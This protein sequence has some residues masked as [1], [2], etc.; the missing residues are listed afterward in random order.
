MVGVS[1]NYQVTDGAGRLYAGVRFGAWMVPVGLAGLA[2]LV[3]AT[4]N[5]AGRLRP[6]M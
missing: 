6:S 2:A 5:W 1:L 4:Y 3:G